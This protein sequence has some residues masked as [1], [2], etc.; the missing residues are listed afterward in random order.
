MI[1]IITDGMPDSVQNVQTAMNV[2]EQN[3]VEV[4]GISIRSRTI[5][6]LFEKHP[7][8]VTLLEDASELNRAFTELFKKQFAFQNM[9]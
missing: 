6:I 9:A 3:G 5:S 7:E 8:N 1:F 4:Y 2:L